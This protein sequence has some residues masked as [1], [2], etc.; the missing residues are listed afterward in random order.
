MHAAVTCLEAD[1]TIFPL[2]LRVWRKG[3]HKW[4]SCATGPYVYAAPF[5]A[6]A[7]RAAE[8][9]PADDTLVDEAGGDASRAAGG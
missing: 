1:R 2:D 6:E 8:A 7:G 3:L 5:T 4:Q 9:A